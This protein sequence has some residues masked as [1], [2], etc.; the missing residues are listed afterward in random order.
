MPKNTTKKLKSVFLKQS[1]RRILLL[2]CFFLLNV[3]CSRPSAPFF[4]NQGYAALKPSKCFIVFLV[5]ARHLDYSHPSAL[6]RTLIKHP[7]D[8]SKSHDVGHAWI[9]LKGTSQG[10]TVIVEGG[11][12]G[13]LGVIQ[14]KYF[15]GIMNYLDYGVRDPFRKSLRCYE[16]NPVKYLWETQNDGFFENGSGRHTPTFAVKVNI[17]EMQ[18]CDIL[19]FV[20]SYNYSEYRLTN[21]QCCTFIAEIGSRVGLLLNHQITLDIPQN[22]Y[23][24]GR[25]I[26]LWEDPSYSKLTFSSPDR[27]EKSLMK[28]VEEGKGEYVL[29][30]YKADKRN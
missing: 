22:L 25:K 27:I 2:I 8:W 14:P 29:D 26:R 7:D 1:Y 21:H 23:F 12:S 3:C 30:W 6:L 17:T 20:Q 11:H 18:F 9:Y 19:N 10:Q 15:D 4:E 13:E 5:N 28:L 16:P 24:R